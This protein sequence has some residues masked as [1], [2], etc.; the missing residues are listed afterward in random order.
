MVLP[1]TS[2]H[3]VSCAPR[4][5]VCL[6]LLLVNWLWQADGGGVRQACRAQEVL[7]VPCSPFRFLS[8][9]ACF[10]NWQLPCLLV[11]AGPF[12]LVC[13]RLHAR[14]HIVV[15]MRTSEM[16]SSIAARLQASVAATRSTLLVLS[17]HTICACSSRSM[18]RHGQRNQ[19]SS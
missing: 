8:L 3:N 6:R 1:T 16:S 14:S 11:V 17:T 2:V 15:C 4:V 12:S 7:P 10:K 19:T 13:H 5:L 9:S 18:C